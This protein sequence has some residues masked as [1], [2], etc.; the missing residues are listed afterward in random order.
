MRR[1]TNLIATRWALGALL[2]LALCAG[3]AMAAE[4]QSA[5][6]PLGHY[7]TA[8]AIADP[9]SEDMTCSATAP[10]GREM[11]EDEV[12]FSVFFDESEG[13]VYIN[14]QS[15]GT[16]ESA[17]R[18]SVTAECYQ[19]DGIWYANIAVRDLD[20]SETVGSVT[21]YEMNQKPATVSVTAENVVS[22]NDQ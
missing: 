21:A 13:E 8:V 3:S 14:G 5:S 1:E 11:N 16:Y 9:G 12:Q 15:V 19:L 18:F 17:H 7:F 10:S 6:T 4:T 22:L 20:N 2:A